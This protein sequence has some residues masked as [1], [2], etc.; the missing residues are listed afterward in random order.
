MKMMLIAALLITFPAIVVIGYGLIST[1]YSVWPALASLAL[2]SFPFIL[3]GIWLY[4][5][6]KQ[7]RDQ[8]VDGH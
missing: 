8:G 1:S 2:G 4:F 5:N 6:H 7:G 3:G